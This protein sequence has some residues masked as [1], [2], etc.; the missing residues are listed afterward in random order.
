MNEK[1][2]TVFISYSSRDAVL[3]RRLANDLQ[4]AKLNVW[5]DQWKINVGE[6]FEQ[7]IDR[8][9][10]ACD[11]LVVLL[12][13]H[14]IKSDW[15]DHEWRRKFEAEAVKNQIMVVPVHGDHC[16]LPVF[17]TNR[18]RADISGGSY[19]LGLRYLLDILRHHGDSEKIEAMPLLPAVEDATAPAFQPL[20]TPITIEFST[21]LEPLFDHSLATGSTHSANDLSNIEFLVESMLIDLNTVLGMTYPGY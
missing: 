15:V 21:D 1:Q 3:A 16:D 19:W 13:E 9:V 10:D 20:I 17:L 8:G 18:S 4:Q 6:E 5:L 7:V 12:T 14:S 2:T 11:F